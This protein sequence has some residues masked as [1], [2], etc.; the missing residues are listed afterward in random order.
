MKVRFSTS[1]PDRP[2]TVTTPSSEVTRSGVRI[3]A[4]SPKCRV[5][6]T[7]AQ[8]LNLVTE[9]DI[10]VGI[11]VIGSIDITEGNTLSGIVDIYPT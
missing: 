2:P 5:T 7:E 6:H 1:E 8:G 3:A 10:C 4:E 9:Y 11:E